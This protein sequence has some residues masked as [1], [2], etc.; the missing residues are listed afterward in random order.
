MRPEKIIGFLE[1]NQSGRCFNPDIPVTANL[2]QVRTLFSGV[3][4]KLKDTPLNKLQKVPNIGK[5]IASSI[6]NQVDKL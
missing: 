4:K 2:N 5:E 6:K 3:F 1:L